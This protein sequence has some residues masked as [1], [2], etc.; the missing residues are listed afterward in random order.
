MAAIAPDVLDKVDSDTVVDK[1]SKMY[2][3]DP[4]ILRG[5][6]EI[7]AI[8]DHRAQMAQQQQ[9]MATMQQIGGMAKDY[10]KAMKDGQVQGTQV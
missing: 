1:L 8:R 3:I 5:S 7:Q 10:G 9:Q 6:D 4:D 2:S